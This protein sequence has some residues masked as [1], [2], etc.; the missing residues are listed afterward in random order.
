MFVFLTE[1]TYVTTTTMRTKTA[2]GL[3]D[4]Y[5]IS[6]YRKQR[7]QKYK[8]MMF[9]HLSVSDRWFFCEKRKHEE[10]KEVL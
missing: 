1:T 9:D 7:S 6:D 8:R 4:V 10:S 2:H 3:I 5:R